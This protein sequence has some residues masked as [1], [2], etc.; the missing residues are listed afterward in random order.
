MY[1]NNTNY[2]GSGREYSNFRSTSSPLEH[3]TY[4]ISHPMQCVQSVGVRYTG[5]S[6]QLSVGLNLS[7]DLQYPH[8]YFSDSVYSIL[9]NMRGR[10]DKLENNI[11]SYSLSEIVREYS[12][13]KLSS[14]L[15]ISVRVHTEYIF[16]P[17]PFI[18]PGFEGC[19][20]GVAD[21]VKRYVEDTFM[22]LFGTKFPA[23]IDICVLGEKE[24]R[25]IAPHPDT[26]GL[27][28]NR[29]STGE[30]SQ[31]F[32]LAGSLARV[33]LTLGHELGHVLSPTLSSIHNEEAKAYSFSFAWMD[34]IRKSNIGGL[35]CAFVTENPAHN[36]V[37]DVAYAFVM[38][39]VD[40]GRQFWDIYTDIVERELSM[41]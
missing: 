10:N 32:V 23:H 21:D 22:A 1:T 6:A 4:S 19:F 29:G 27:S 41:S 25:T 30:V 38:K 5:L 13:V 12:T 20:I 15:D 11:G 34:V 18:R 35:G 14:S 36:G 17:A 24:F 26:I 16:D 33:M 39:L 31:V 2:M 28:I 7:E 9:G 3:I 40:S 8:T 37:H